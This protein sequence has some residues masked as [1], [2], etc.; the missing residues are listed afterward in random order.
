MTAPP[1][2][3]TPSDL[4]RIADLTATQLHALL[5]LADEMKDGPTWWNAARH[6][7]A[8]ASASRVRWTGP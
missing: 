5:D 8:V 2:T 6:G 1:I 3:T 4:L 7:T